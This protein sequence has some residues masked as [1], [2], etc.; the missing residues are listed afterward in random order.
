MLARMLDG[1]E[2]PEDGLIPCVAQ[3]EATG[4]VLTLAY[5]SEESLR[6]T[7]ETGEV[8]YFSRSRDEIWHKGATSGNTQRVRG[9]RYDCDGDAILAL[10][11]PAGPACHTGERSCFYRDLG[12]SAPTAHDAARAE[13]EPVPAAFEAPAVLERTLHSRRSSA[14]PAATRS[15]CSTIPAGSAR[16]SPRRRRRWSAPPARRPTSGWPRRPPTSSTI[17]RCCW[18]PGGFR[19][20]M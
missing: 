10:V 7:V 1:L 3:D 5:M 12:G 16:R 2:F 19:G 18:S 14:R 8:H 13:G 15:S 20:G 6:L 17:S 9:L 11:E 4:E